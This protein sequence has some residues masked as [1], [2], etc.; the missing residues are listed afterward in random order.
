[1]AKNQACLLCVFV[2]FF[3]GAYNLRLSR[4]KKFAC[5][6]KFFEPFLALFF[7]I[8]K[9]IAFAREVKTA[10][11]EKIAEISADF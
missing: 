4:A 2:F 1:M 9:K 5:G 10:I 7:A 11:F 8:F 3:E 6:S